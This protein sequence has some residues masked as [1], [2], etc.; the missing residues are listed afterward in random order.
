MNSS[1]RMCQ[2]DRDRFGGPEW[3][4]FDMDAL[5]DLRAAELE[6]I[7]ETTGF[8]LVWF[9]VVDRRVSIRGQRAALWIARRQAGLVDD[10][11]KFDPLIL[12]V[13]PRPVPSKAD[14]ADPPDP[15]SETSS[16]N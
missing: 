6:E 8:R 9:Y 3:V 7:E 2:E 10:W 12:Q 13:E 14:D 4:T 1:F 15:A 16:E 11:D 5:A